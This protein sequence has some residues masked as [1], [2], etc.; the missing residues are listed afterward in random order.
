MSIVDSN[1]DPDQVDYMI[2]AN[3]DAIKSLEYILGL[4]KEAVNTKN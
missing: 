2:P 4:A 1:A 3:D